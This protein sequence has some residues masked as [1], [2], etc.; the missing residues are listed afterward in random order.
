MHR[1][2]HCAV[3]SLWRQ[4]YQRSDWS[5]LA[6]EKSQ[7]AT[8]YWW[9]LTRDGLEKTDIFVNR[10]TTTTKYCR[11]AITCDDMKRFARSISPMI[12][13]NDLV[14][15]GIFMGWDYLKRPYGFGFTKAPEINKVW[16]AADNAGNLA[17]LK[18]IKTQGMPT[19]VR[20]MNTSISVTS[21]PGNK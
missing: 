6:A 16:I 17:I 8:D 2:R 13:S 19:G 7:T 9:H 11:V 5:R 15:I 20:N 21:V 18:N 3:P 14:A 1:K 10:S 4:I 12:L